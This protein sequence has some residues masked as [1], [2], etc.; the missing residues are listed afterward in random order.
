M[1]NSAHIHDSW[2]IYGSKLKDE[3][4]QLH[5]SL[6]A[7]LIRCPHPLSSSAVVSY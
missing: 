4:H 5:G 2:F 6:F 7:V 3:I 1:H